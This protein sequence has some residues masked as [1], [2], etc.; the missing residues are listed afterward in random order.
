M[1]SKVM[2]AIESKCIDP[3]PFSV[4]VGLV[5]IVGGVLQVIGYCEHRLSHGPA[6]TRAGVGVMME[7]LG[8]DLR[9]I[10]ADVTVIRDVVAKGDMPEGRAFRLSNRV[11]FESHDFDRY[12]RAVDQVYARLRSVLRNAHKVDRL[13]SNLPI[14]EQAAAVG[15][16]TQV[17]L[18]LDALIRA[19][20][21]PVEEALDT[22]V[23]SIGRAVEAINRLLLGLGSAGVSPLLNP[24]PGP[25]DEPPLRPTR[26][27]VFTSD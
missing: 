9:R 11:L 16:L 18:H 17:I 5:G 3:D 14:Q 24:S 15:G 19:Q 21:C 23:V 12:A 26:R 6:R 13:L 4:L 1:E 22:V 25:V 8:D 27:I 20:A 2:K 10:A 7:R